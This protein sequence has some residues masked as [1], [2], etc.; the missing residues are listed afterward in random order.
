MIHRNL[1]PANVMV[2]AYGE[3]QVVD[4]GLAKLLARD[5]APHASVSSAAAPVEPLEVNVREQ[6]SLVGTVMG[7]LAYMPPEQAHGEVDKLD[8][9]ADA[10]A[11]G[12][13]L[14]EILTGGAPYSGTASQV[15]VE[16]ARGMLGPAFEE[17]DRAS[18]PR[19]DRAVQTLPR[20]RA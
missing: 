19:A 17:L 20:A 6:H 3:V 18:R 12:A 9:R 10:F 1:K 7:T 4:W 14:C 16:A 15:A 8:E 2:G 11:L 13:M 5:E